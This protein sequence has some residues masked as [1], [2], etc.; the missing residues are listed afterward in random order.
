LILRG[1]NPLENI[2]N[3]EKRVG[4]MLKGK[5]YA[6]TELT[7]WLGEI[8]PRIENSYIEKK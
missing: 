3:T 1:A 7:R 4:I 2:T 8:A 6:Q 5:Y